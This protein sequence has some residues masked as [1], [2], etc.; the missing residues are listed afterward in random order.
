MGTW[1]GGQ[2]KH[3]T[4]GKHNGR[5]KLSEEDVNNIRRAVKLDDELSQK[6]LARGYRVSRV[7]IHKILTRKTWKH[8]PD[9]VIPRFSNDQDIPSPQE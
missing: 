2:P 3:G 1:T 6:T 4:K 9:P 5:A 8:L 7:A